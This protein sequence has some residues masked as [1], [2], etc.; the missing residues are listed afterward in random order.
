MVWRGIYT[1]PDETIAAMVLGWTV[2]FAELYG[3]LQYGLFTYQ[4]W[5]PVE[6]TAHPLTSHPT[7]DMMVT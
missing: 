7:V 3:L 5:S 6:R 2:F 4:V 1:I